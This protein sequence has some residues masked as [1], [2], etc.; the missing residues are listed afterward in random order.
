MSDGLE[1]APGSLEGL[2]DG[3]LFRRQGHALVDRLAD[4]LLEAKGAE[5][6]VLP[7]VEPEA[8]SGRWAGAFPE[9]PGEGLL[10]VLERV[11][12][13]ANHL[14]HP[15]HMGHQVGIPLPGAALCDLVASLLNNGMAV[16]EHGAALDANIVCFRYTPE[17]GG[18]LDALQAAVRKRILE[19]ERFYVVQARLP[20]GLFLRTALMNPFTGVEHLQELLEA[21]RACA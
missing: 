20:Q 6:P 18:D 10:G 9:G 3:E 4:Y 7:W 8:M 5:L 21:I 17:G 15:R 2:F 11:V 13:G 16:Y 14:Q 12:A 19:Q 1:R